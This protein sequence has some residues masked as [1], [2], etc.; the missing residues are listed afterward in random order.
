MLGSQA[1]A[2]AIMN[3]KTILSSD[4]SQVRP[5]ESRQS[6]AWTIESEL[7]TLET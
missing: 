2:L 7:A 1:L 6:F 4:I 3:M 5:L